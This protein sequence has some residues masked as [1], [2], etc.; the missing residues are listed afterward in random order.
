MSQQEL[1]I[2]KSHLFKKLIQKRVKMLQDER[3]EMKGQINHLEHRLTRS[4]ARHA[5]L[6]G[7]GMQ[8]VIA[9][10]II[11]VRKLRERAEEQADVTLKIAQ[12]KQEQ[13]FKEMDNLR[14]ECAQLNQIVNEMIEAVHTIS[15]QTQSSAALLIQDATLQQEQLISQL[16]NLYNEDGM[17]RMAIVEARQSVFDVQKQARVEA[18]R[19]DSKTEAERDRLSTQNQALLNES[20]KLHGALLSATEAAHT[21]HSWTQLE[22]AQAVLEVHSATQ[23]KDM[24]DSSANQEED[25]LHDV[26]GFFSVN[27]DFVL[28]VARTAIRKAEEA[29]QAEQ[30]AQSAQSAHDLPNSNYTVNQATVRPFWQPS[31]TYSTSPDLGLQ[32]MRASDPLFMQRIMLTLCLCLVIVVGI[33]MVL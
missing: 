20:R 18:K 26:Q 15:E 17:L 6:S 23:N 10:T 16:D 5:A 9:E 13:L 11:D 28:K 21:I 25:A 24:T 4:T 8:K 32:V 7:G 2:T 27:D 30:S 22:A 3:S 19:L 31:S 1:Q 33:A 29:E 14:D 12:P